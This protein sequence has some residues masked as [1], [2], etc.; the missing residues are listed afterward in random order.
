MNI[1]LTSTEDGSNKFWSIRVDGAS[2][3]VTFGRVGSR[4]QEKTKTFASE[5]AALADAE[6][7]VRSKRSGGYV[8]EGGSPARPAAAPAPGKVPNG[9]PSAP[10]SS[11]GGVIIEDLPILVRLPLAAHAGRVACAVGDGLVVVRHAGAR[12][13]AEAVADDANLENCV[14]AVAGDAVFYCDADGALHV[15]M[16]GGTSWKN[17][18]IFKQSESLVPGG[19]GLAAAQSAA[20]VLW[21]VMVDREEDAVVLSNRSGAFAVEGHVPARGRDLG[22]NVHRFLDVACAGEVPMVATLDGE[23]LKV[24]RLENGKFVQE[25][26]RKKAGGWVS[27][28]A[29]PAGGLHVAY[30]NWS[31]P[32]NDVLEVAT[33]T[34]GA[35]EFHTADKKGNA[36]YVA[37]IALVG[38]V[39]V[40][41]HAERS[42]RYG[43]DR[44]ALSNKDVRLVQRQG[45]G[46]GAVSLGTGRWALALTEVAGRAVV[47][48]GP[49]PLEKSG[50]LRALHAGP[51][52][53]A[54]GAPIDG[55]P[56]PK[57]LLLG[58]LRLRLADELPVYLESKG[59]FWEITVKGS[60]HTVRT[61]KVGAAGASKS[62]TFASAAEAQA[63]GIKLLEK[64]V[65]SEYFRE[66][67][68]A[69]KEEGAVAEIM[70]KMKAM[71]QDE[72]AREAAQSD[73]RQKSSP[74]GWP[75]IWDTLGETGPLVGRLRGVIA[76]GEIREHLGEP[77]RIYFKAHDAHF[78]F[79]G[80]VPHPLPDFITNAERQLV[81]SKGLAAALK[82]VPGLEPLPVRLV[83]A[84]G[85]E[86]S[87]DYVLLEVQKTS[88]C[89]EGD[90]E[91]DPT[92]YYYAHVRAPRVGKVLGKALP[93]ISRAKRTLLIACNSDIA[94]RVA[95]FSGVRLLPLDQVDE[96]FWPPPDAEYLVARAGD[97]TQFELFESEHD[98]EK[99]FETG[100]SAAS[101]W[102]NDAVLSMTGNKS[103]KK[104]TSFMHAPGAPVVSADAKALLEKLGAT[105]IEFLPVKLLDHGK[106]DV[107]G[108]FYVMNVLAARAY[109]HPQE[110]DLEVEYKYLWK[111]R[112]LVVDEQAVADRPALFRLPGARF[113]WVFVRRDVLAAIE[114]AKL[115][116]FGGSHPA[117]YEFPT[118]GGGLEKF[119]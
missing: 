54:A 105:E 79:R 89:I 72:L 34:G 88:A 97:A 13:V 83:D 48:A 39:P 26:E 23:T 60:G 108:S 25:M 95:P 106:K 36:G 102:P 85:A 29:D 33:R 63:A 61:G 16:P 53:H 44:L 1:R 111:V 119:T 27:M 84:S 71:A 90:G 110:S 38:G 78:A 73:E 75:I 20:G 45:A 31:G 17:D 118:E 67:E 103:W 65:H 107:P 96:K 14:P 62:A 115:T 51:A 93:A 91:F 68:V 77:N 113:P 7:L 41:A 32:K 15:C 30:L 66:P 6:K 40:V 35:W 80:A 81:V 116:G 28:V 42:T 114:A 43:G 52:L 76:R 9:A 24:L 112:E 11:A 57:V 59:R 18:V 87:R 12:F 19:R 82:G 69:A 37:R 8:D 99:S 101:L 3:T 86:V 55:A 92:S 58:G 104:I 98:F 74:D 5:S 64:K 94:A 4:G 46:W 22:D 117:E 2:H 10:S 100:Q 109:A 50:R 56:Q 70:A 47:F 49:E 21:V